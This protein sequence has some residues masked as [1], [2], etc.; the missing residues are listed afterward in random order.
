MPAILSNAR[1]FLATSDYPLDKVCYLHSATVNFG[2]GTDYTVAHGL[3][4]TPLIRAVWS[5]TSSFT[6]AYQVGDGPV[7]S[8]PSTPFSP[9][10]VSAYADS[11]N[12]VLSFGMPGTTT[13][14]YVRIYALMPGGDSSEVSH[15]ASSADDFTLSTDYNY[16]KLY[17]EG[18]T[19]SSSTPSSTEIVTHSLGYYPQVEVWFEKSSR[20]Y[21]ASYSALVNGSPTSEAFAISTSSLTMTRE[22]FLSGPESFHYRIYVDELA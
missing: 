21:A 11:T 4:F 17:M 10:L 3:P 15:T 16:T 6:T 22:M 2:S 5:L 20:I 19:A 13:Q 12:A 18:E 1:D 7:S 9:Q 14:V 8:S